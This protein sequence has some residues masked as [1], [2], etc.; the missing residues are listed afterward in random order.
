[1][2]KV[3][4]VGVHCVPE[5]NDIWFQGASTASAGGN[6]K[7]LHLLLCEKDVAVRGQAMGLGTP[8]G[9]QG[10]EAL[11]QHLTRSLLSTIQAEDP[12]T[13]EAANERLSWGGT[14]P[15]L[16]SPSIITS[17]SQRPVLG[18]ASHDLLTTSV[19]HLPPLST[20]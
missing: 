13:K 9:V 17:F 4:L 18:I 16:F 3:D 8:G 10:L 2:H 14:S 15:S 19:S 6:P 1:M 5:E 7:A 11:L 12:E 20:F